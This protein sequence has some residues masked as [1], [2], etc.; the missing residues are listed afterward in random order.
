MV[1][2]SGVVKVGVQVMRSWGCI[3]YA[4]LDACRV[5]EDISTCRPDG[6]EAA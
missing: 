6:V 2:A 3:V 1:V 5:L 4:D